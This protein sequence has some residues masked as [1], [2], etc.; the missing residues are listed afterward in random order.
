MLLVFNV[1]TLFGFVLSTE[2]RTKVLT[3]EE[4]LYLISKFLKELFGAKYLP[5][6]FELFKTKNGYIIELAELLRVLL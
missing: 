6:F 2:F 3:L 5:S 1:A 4:E